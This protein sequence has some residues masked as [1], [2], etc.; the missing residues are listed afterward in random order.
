MIKNKKTRKN[1]KRRSKNRQRRSRKVM[2]GGAGIKVARVAR[3]RTY[4]SGQISPIEKSR[5]IEASM[6]GMRK[7]ASAVSA[8]PVNK[9]AAYT[10]QDAKKAKKAEQ[11]RAGLEALQKMGFAVSSN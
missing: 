4:S 10:A 6:A 7:S 5:M 9:W 1:S 11:T 3:A 2:R 8:V